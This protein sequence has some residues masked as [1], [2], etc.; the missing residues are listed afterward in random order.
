MEA[1]LANA[2]LMLESSHR[3]GFPSGT[4]SKERRRKKDDERKTKKDEERR[5]KKKKAELESAWSSI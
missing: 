5:K 4:T 1:T 3:E 2:G